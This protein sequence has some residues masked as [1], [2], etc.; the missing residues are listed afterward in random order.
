MLLPL[1]TKGICNR[2]LALRIDDVDVD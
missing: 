2:L 1:L